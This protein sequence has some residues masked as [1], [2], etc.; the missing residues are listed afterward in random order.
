V[1]TAIRTHFWRTGAAKR[2]MKSSETVDEARQTAGSRGG[3]FWWMSRSGGTGALR[4]LGGIKAGPNNRSRIRCRKLHW[5]R[6]KGARERERKTGEMEGP[7]RGRAATE[8]TGWA[9]EAL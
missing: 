5:G 2:K 3:L 4:R 9:D 1:R 7:G 6:V 8:A